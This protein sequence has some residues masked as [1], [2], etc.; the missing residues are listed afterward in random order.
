MGG[1]AAE[2]PTV[3]RLRGAPGL[4]VHRDGPLAVEASIPRFD[5]ALW[6][7]VV[8]DFPCQSGED[9]CGEGELSAAAVAPVALRPLQD[10]PVDAHCVESP[11]E[12][13]RDHFNEVTRLFFDPVPHRAGV[14]IVDACEL[15]SDRVLH[16]F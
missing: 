1:C 5:P 4:G 14:G 2:G 16:R 9:G 3:G 10:S 11:V 7:T 13:H 15:A 12:H 8:G 6:L